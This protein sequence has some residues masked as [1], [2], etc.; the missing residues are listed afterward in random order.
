[1][2]RERPGEANDRQYVISSNETDRHSKTLG[3]MDYEEFGKKY[4]K[5]SECKHNNWNQD[6]ICIACGEV[7]DK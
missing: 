2:I 4:E 5:W 7:V 3:G 6:K 1:M